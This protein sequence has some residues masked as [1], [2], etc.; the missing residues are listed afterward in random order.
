MSVRLSCLPVLTTT[1]TTTKHHKPPYARDLV[2]LALGHD[3][4]AEGH[5][6]LRRHGVGLGY[7]GNQRHAL[8]DGRHELEVDRL[9]PVRRDEVQ[10]DVDLMCAIWSGMGA[11]EVDGMRD[12]SMP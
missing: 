1:T 6:L 5:R 4:A 11:N 3:L 2:L 9:E 12:L 8:R 7:D 10:A